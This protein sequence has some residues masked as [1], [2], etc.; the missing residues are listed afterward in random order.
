MNVEPEAKPK[1]LAFD[2]RKVGLVGEHNVLDFIGALA[3]V[4]R[5][6]D[7]KVVRFLVD[8]VKLGSK[9]LA[10]SRDLDAVTAEGLQDRAG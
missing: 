6:N 9:A 7:L 10:V 8:R 1:D 4:R 2:L 5:S 3:L